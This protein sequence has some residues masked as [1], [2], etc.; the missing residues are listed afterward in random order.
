MSP[1][2]VIVG[3]SIQALTVLHLIQLK[4]GGSYKN[5]MTILEELK[6]HVRGIFL[7]W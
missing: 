7:I 3:T 2:V 1:Q 5:S 4:I 6:R